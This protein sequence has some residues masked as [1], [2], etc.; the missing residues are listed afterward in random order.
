MVFQS[1]ALWPHLTVGE[2]I[3]YGLEVM[4]KSRGELAKALDEVKRVF[5]FAPKFSVVTAAP[6]SAEVRQTVTL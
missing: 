1:Y 4:G 3:V 5:S 6:D 2:N